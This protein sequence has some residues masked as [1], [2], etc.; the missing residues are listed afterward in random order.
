[1]NVSKPTLFFILILS[2]G[3]LFSQSNQDLIIIDEIADDITELL[4]EFGNQPNVYVTDANTP[5]ALAQITEQL[6]NL[7][8]AD[9][10]IY[11][12]T[13]PGAIVFSS[14][15]ITT[16][17]IDELPFDLTDWTK[18]ISGKVVIHSDVVFTGEE[19]ILL[20][21]QLESKS[22]LVFISQL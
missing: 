13:K 11:V 12:P 3:H 6:V 15:A 14:I 21:Q 8:I 4:A 1:M 16:E 19:G 17:N 20:K 22:G 5:D 7:R 18:V 10:H 9:L 2:A